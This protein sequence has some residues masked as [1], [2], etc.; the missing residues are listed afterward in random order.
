MQSSAMATLS[1]RDLISMHLEDLS[2]PEPVSPAGLRIAHDN[3]AQN[4]KGDSK[5]AV[6]LKVC[7]TLEGESNLYRGFETQ[8]IFVAT[9]QPLEKGTDVNV[10]FFTEDGAVGR[11]AGVVRWVRD[12]HPAFPDTTPGMAVELE[13]L[14]GDSQ[15]V[16]DSFAKRRDP[17]FYD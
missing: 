8:G 16:F 11:A 3:V 1:L 7:L 12:Y 14:C 2:Q 15:S 5:Q 17:L 10:T 9:W 4:A 6:P 13:D